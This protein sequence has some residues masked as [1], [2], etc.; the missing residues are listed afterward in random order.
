M[1]G[2]I[3]VI[4][5]VMMMPKM[6]S[7]SALDSGLTAMVG[8]LK[9]TNLV[10]TVDMMKDVTVFAPSNAAFKAIG[11]TASMLSMQQLSS[12]LEYHVV[13]G[14]V[15]YSTLLTMG[16][17]N[18]TMTTLQGA[19]LKVMV[20]NNKVFVNSAQVETEDIVVNNG[21][22]HVINAYVSLFHSSPLKRE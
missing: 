18:K 12:V 11:G 7:E 1:G 13:K 5:N 16:L 8:A 2:V 21:V 15:G 20:E 10:M 17:A 6:V 14:T 4:D 22:M 3:H 9:N 19:T